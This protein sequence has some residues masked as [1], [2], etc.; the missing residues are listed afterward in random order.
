MASSGSL[1][2]PRVIS[3]AI[4]DGQ[5]LVRCNVALDGVLYTTI[6]TCGKE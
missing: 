4:Y 5:L 1:A 2:T 6:V 3:C